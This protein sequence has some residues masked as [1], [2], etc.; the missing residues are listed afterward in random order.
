MQGS[1][2]RRGHQDTSHG[3]KKA[4]T[5]LRH[6]GCRQYVAS[7]Q[8][9]EARRKLLGQLQLRRREKRVRDACVWPHGAEF[10]VHNS[11]SQMHAALDGI[12]RAIALRKTRRIARHVPS[13][14]IS[15]LTPPQRTRQV[16]QLAREFA[17]MVEN[18]VAVA[19][20]VQ[21]EQFDA[22]AEWLRSDDEVTVLRK[23]WA[24]LMA[25]LADPLLSPFFPRSH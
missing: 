13:G 20:G 22:T 3:Q 9:L 19:A 2:R 11:S 4:R 8:E 23:K 7:Q 5:R 17:K 6:S 18:P 1:L 12:E 25:A 24:I 10:D 21:P 15:M 16:L 14:R